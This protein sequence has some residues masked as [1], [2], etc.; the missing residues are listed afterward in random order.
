MI[1]LKNW[2]F[3]R[4]WDSANCMPQG[5]WS[6]SIPEA[7]QFKDYQVSHALGLVVWT[8]HW[9]TIMVKWWWIWNAEFSELSSWKLLWDLQPACKE[10]FVFSKEHILLLCVME[11]E[12]QPLRAGFSIISCRRAQTIRG[13]CC[14]WELTQCQVYLVDTYGTH[15]TWCN[16]C[17]ECH[18]CFVILFLVCESRQSSAIVMLQ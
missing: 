9:C 5:L 4:P 6:S 1:I 14:T 18:S 11:K 10:L 13:S 8:S 12:T 7:Q 3:E 15:V 16:S 2:N 17:M